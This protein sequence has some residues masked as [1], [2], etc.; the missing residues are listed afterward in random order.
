MLLLNDLNFSLKVLRQQKNSD[1]LKIFRHSL[2]VRVEMTL[3]FCIIT[4]YSHLWLGAYCANFYIYS[5]Y[6]KYLILIIKII[7][8][9]V[10]KD[11]SILFSILID[12]VEKCQE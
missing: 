12:K 4:I 2:Q 6:Q 7:L 11:I 8:Y 9:D 1:L 5:I 10:I 3:Y